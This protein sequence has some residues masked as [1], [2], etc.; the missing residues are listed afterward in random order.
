MRTQLDFIKVYNWRNVTNYTQPYH[1]LKLGFENGE[2]GVLITERY[3]STGQYIAFLNFVPKI[4][5][6]DMPNSLFE[7]EHEVCY[8]SKKGMLE[9]K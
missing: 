5:I 9:N 3:Y 7:T 8:T 4:G 2:V 6:S 1:V